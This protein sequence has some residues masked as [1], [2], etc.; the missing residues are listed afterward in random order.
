MKK[1]AENSNENKPEQ[2][3][4]L[5]RKSSYRQSIKILTSA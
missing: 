4:N 5:A 3:K 2:R 1:T